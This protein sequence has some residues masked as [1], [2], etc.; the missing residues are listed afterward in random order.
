MWM[1]FPVKDDGTLGAGKVFRDVTKSVGK[2][3]PG[4][5][6]GMK[7]DAKGN[8]FATG[9]GGVLVFTAEGKHLGTIATG[10]PT[11][12]CAWGDDGSMLYVTADKALTRI[13]TKTKG[14]GF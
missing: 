11:A 2:D 10:V 13:K 5:P 14:K 4:L 6:D 7:V 8:L 3:K 1:A 12:N 9:P